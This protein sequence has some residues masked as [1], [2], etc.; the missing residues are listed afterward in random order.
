MAERGLVLQG[1]PINDRGSNKFFTCL[2]GRFWI[3]KNVFVG[4]MDGSK[5]PKLQAPKAYDDSLGDLQT[6]IS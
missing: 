3:P 5:T 6:K 1:L 4:E 2:V